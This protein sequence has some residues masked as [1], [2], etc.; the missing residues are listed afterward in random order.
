[1]NQEQN[2]HVN[3]IR[4]GMIEVLAPQMVCTNTGT[5]SIYRHLFI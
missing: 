1:M 3:V 2:M 4:C 5:S